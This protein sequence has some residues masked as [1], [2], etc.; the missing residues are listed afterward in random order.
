MQRMQLFWL[1]QLMFFLCFWSV[2]GL[3]R[4]GPGPYLNEKK[5]SF[6]LE[7]PE[8]WVNKSLSFEFC[9]YSDLF[10]NPDF[11]LRTMKLL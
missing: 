6:E 5:K 10:P 2:A 8:L 3:K 7:K 1:M 4:W 9:Y 11:A